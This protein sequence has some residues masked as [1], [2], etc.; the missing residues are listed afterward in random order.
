M[1]I[2]WN[3]LL[4][5][6][7]LHFGVGNFFGVRNTLPRQMTP[8]AAAEGTP[9]ADIRDVNATS[10]ASMVHVMTDA[11]PHTTVTALLG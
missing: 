3:G 2:I 10:D 4:K 5:R 8:Y 9:A 6:P 11:T 7:K 1:E